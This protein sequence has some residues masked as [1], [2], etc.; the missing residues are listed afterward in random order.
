MKRLVYPF[1]LIFIFSM[2][3]SCSTD[4]K[5]MLFNGDDLEN[6]DIL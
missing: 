3:V 5:V 2:V 6:W 4:N 1:A